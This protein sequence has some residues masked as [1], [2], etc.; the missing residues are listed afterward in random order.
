[1]A[2][3]TKGDL[4]PISVKMSCH[5]FKPGCDS[6]MVW[7]AVLVQWYNRSRSSVVKLSESPSAQLMETI[8]WPWPGDGRDD[9][10]VLAYTQKSVGVSHI[11]E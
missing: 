3:K 6:A 5:R 10:G 9:G 11:H 8:G 4:N 1:M 2:R 7:L